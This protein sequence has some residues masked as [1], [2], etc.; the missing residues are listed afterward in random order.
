[1]ATIATFGVVV[2]DIAGRAHRLAITADTSPNSTVVGEMITERGAEISAALRDMGVDVD[3]VSADST[4]QVYQ[5]ARRWIIYGVAADVLLARD[6]TSTDLADAYE[7]R[8]SEA[9]DRLSTEVSRMLADG[10]PINDGAANLPASH[11]TR[12]DEIESA[13]EVQGLGQRLAWS[14]SV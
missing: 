5:I 12:A 1:M 7:R 14:G 3:T 4:L 8:T 6:R 10:R 9:W 13:I 2:S 11:V